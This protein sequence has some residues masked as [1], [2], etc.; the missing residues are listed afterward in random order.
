MTK[1]LQLPNSEP[2]TTQS[3]VS[4]ATLAPP[5]QA[6]SLDGPAKAA[7]IVRLLQSEGADLPL[8]S[9]PENLQ[10]ALTQQM[11]C[12]GLVDRETLFDVAQEFAALLDGVGLT[13]PSTMQDALDAMDGKISPQTAARLRK[14]A[15]V[16]M[17]G[18]PWDMLAELPPED[19]APMVLAESTEVA[20]VIL[21]KLEVPKAASLLRV[22]PGADARRIALAV[23]QTANVTPD[24][25]DRIGLALASQI[26]DQPVPAFPKDPGHRMGDILNVSSAELRDDLLNAMAEEDAGFASS[27][28]EFIFTFAHIP[29]RIEQR[30]IPQIVKRLDPADLLNALASSNQGPDAKAADYILNNISSRM[31]DGLRDEMSE[32]KAVK[33]SD[34]ERAQNAVIAV[35]QDMLTQGDIQL[36][37]RDED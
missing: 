3:N 34:G 2:R 35:V 17:S 1:E 19:L 6:A 30:D 15:G 26:L 7:I 37:E 14:E 23:S 21:S 11:S 36:K 4:A 12:M 20:A 32:M 27:V 5:S 22:L 25:V 16:R 13:F 28:R 8:D 33:K 9:L 18:N 10:V 29:E 31:A 24:V